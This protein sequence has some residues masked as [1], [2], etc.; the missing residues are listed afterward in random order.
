MPSEASQNV[1]SQARV[2]FDSFSAAS[3]RAAFLRA[4][5]DNGQEE[6]EWLDFKGCLEG[7]PAKGQNQLPPPAVRK[8]FSEAMCGFANTSGGVLIWGIDCA[9][10]AGDDFDRASGFA[11]A[12]APA[13][14]KAKLK[15]LAAGACDPP[16][17]GVEIE[18]V[19]DTEEPGKGFIVCFVPESRYRPHRAEMAGRRYVIRAGDAFR[20]APVPLLRH[21]FHPMARPIFEMRFQ[22]STQNLNG[23]SSFR[24]FAILANKGTLT[25]RDMFVKIKWEP[26]RPNMAFSVGPGWTTAPG[27]VAGPRHHLQCSTPLHPGADCLLFVLDHPLSKPASKNA[28]GLTAA[29]RDS[30][31]FES[32]LDL[33]VETFAEDAE[34][35]FF[36]TR[37]EVE[38]I[39]SGISKIAESAPL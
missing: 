35:T 4:L 2:F 11:R 17:Q 24:L 37:F 29:I 5:V 33:G 14:F 21:M 3:D 7:D 25:A 30:A 38:E 18:A 23:I 31:G 28:T 10:R 16:L 27:F 26:Q 32:A 8:V 39:G 20:D 1:P 34:A 12:E 15:D 13:K 19:E 9:K 22:M 6:T 36:K